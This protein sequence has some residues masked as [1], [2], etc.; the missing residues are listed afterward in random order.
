MW[1]LERSISES[2]VSVRKDTSAGKLNRK[3]QWL[4]RA[5]SQEGSAKG[6]QLRE[7]HAQVCVLFCHSVQ[8]VVNGVWYS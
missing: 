1:M 8:T 2:F 5:L 6:N 4:R 7:F 3:D